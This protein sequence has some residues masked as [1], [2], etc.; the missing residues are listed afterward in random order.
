MMR[1][2]ERDYRAALSSRVAT[3]Y[4]WLFKFKLDKMK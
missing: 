2:S 1:M 4:M 3:G